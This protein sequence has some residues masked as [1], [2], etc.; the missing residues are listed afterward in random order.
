M[1]RQPGMISFAGGLPDP[2][3]FPVGPF[4]DCAEVL[5]RDGRQV[6]QYGASEGY[7]PLRG[8]LLELMEDRLGT[9]VGPEQLL[10]TSGSQ[11]GLNLVARVLL[12]PGD[13]VVI[14]APT[15]PGTI[16]SLRNTGA[17][18]ATIPCD[19]EGMQVELLP[20]IVEAS[21]ATTGQRPS[22]STRCPIFPTRPA[23]A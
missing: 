13:V 14:E 21:V 23:P 18:F 11:Q 19:A 17:R 1:I 8:F 10:V 7:P 15:Y 16:H 22:S 4:A 9:S 12:D 3:A 20:G 2:S 5:S 6:L